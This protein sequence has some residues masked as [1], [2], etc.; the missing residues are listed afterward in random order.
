MYKIYRQKTDS[1]CLT[2]ENSKL[3]TFYKIEQHHLIARISQ[4]LLN[5]NPLDFVYIYFAVLIGD[6]LIISII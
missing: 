2:M 6:D 5:S 4:Q 1:S 3:L